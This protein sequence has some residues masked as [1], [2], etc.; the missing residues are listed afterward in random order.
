MLR[1]VTH[2]TKV[3]TSLI[4]EIHVHFKVIVR[5]NWWE[6]GFHLTVTKTMVPTMCT[7]VKLVHVLL[8][9]RSESTGDITVQLKF[10]C[11]CL[12]CFVKNISNRLICGL[13]P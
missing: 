6:C 8:K 9:I 10:V 4:A 5:I 1:A 7:P 3:L 2:S 12:A 11:H 13:S